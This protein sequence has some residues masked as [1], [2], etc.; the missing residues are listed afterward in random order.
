MDAPN[1]SSKDKTSNNTESQPQKFSTADV[2]KHKMDNP[3]STKNNF[4]GA[5]MD[6][7]Y[8]GN[9]HAEWERMMKKTSRGRAGK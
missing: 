6:T 8:N 7:S 1:T 2:I 3:D 9:M 5:Y 4:F